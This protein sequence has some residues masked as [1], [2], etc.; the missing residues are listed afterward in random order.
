MIGS[1]VHERRGQRPGQHLGHRAVDDLRERGAR[2]P[3]DVL[4]HPVEHDDR[5]VQRVAQDG[6]QRGHGRC[7]HLPAGQRVD[8][9]GDQQVVHQ[10]DQHG[11]RELPLEPQRHVR[12]DHQQRGDDRDR[13]R[14]WRRS[15]RTSARPTSRRSSTFD[16]RSLV[17][18]ALRTLATPAGC[19]CLAE[20]WKTFAPSALLRDLL[21][22]GSSR[23][24]ALTTE[25][26]LR[27]RWRACSGAAVIRVPEVKSIPRFSP[28]PPIASAPISRITPDS[29]KKYLRGAHE[30][31]ASSAALARRRRAPTGARSSAS[32]P[33]S[34]GS[35]GSPSPP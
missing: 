18:S 19:S 11:H 23:P 8:A 1:S 28:R 22:L 30:V 27:P 35:P 15:C 24:A 33:S 13:R 7:R 31:E 5:V 2:H 10:R 12:G 26:D 4:P 16:A 20:I 34:S 17:C 14:C 32:C 21:D 9:A 29:E 6:Q 25:R 3:R